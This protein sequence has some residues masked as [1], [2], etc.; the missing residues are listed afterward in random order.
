MVESM[1]YRKQLKKVPCSICNRVACLAH[2]EGHIIG[3]VV[4]LNCIGEDEIKG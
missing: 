2:R 3:D 1:I 4:C